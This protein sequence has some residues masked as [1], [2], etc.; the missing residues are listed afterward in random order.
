MR[1]A[2]R[3]G[4]GI[5]HW[6]YGCY[7]LE[8]GEPTAALY[9]F[10]IAKQELPASPV[11]ESSLGIPYFLKRD[12]TNALAHFEESTRL[13]PRHSYGYAWVGRVFEER[14]E[15]EKAIEAHEKCDLMQSQNQEATKRFYQ[16]LREE[17][18]KDPQKGYWRKHLAVALS[19]SRTNTYEVACLYLHMGE[20]RQAYA[21]L[22]SVRVDRG[23]WVD[24]CWD[25]KNEEY[26][27]FAR[28]FGLKP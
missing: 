2:S 19:Q 20:K 26:L 6:L 5:V 12:F 22:Q 25:Q 24:P 7:L 13:E 8:S 10:E 21:L 3:E 27:K 18:K 1:A 15:F 28:R 23:L 16:Q 4:V 9:H 11:I 14:G 17:V